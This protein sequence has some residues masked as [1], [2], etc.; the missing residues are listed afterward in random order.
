MTRRF[1]DALARFSLIAAIILANPA[2][3]LS[4]KAAGENLLNDRSILFDGDFS[5]T[6]HNGRPFHLNQ[7]R[8]K[9]ALLFFGY[10]SCA[11][12]CPVAMAKVASVYK[13][14]GGKQQK[15]ATLFVSLDTDRDTP[16]VLAK[17][18]NYFPIK[19]TG[20]TGKRAEIDAVVKQYGAKYEI[21]KSDS[22]LG[23]HINHSTYLYAIDAHGKVR[24]RFNHTD[25]PELI[26]AGLRK[27]AE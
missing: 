25:S 7:H 12:A 26:A 23:Y 13:K 8:G 1:I 20:L 16:A 10:T 17:Y 15:M 11:E 24:F 18:L 4:A 5:L 2:S 27:L 21:E 22:A 3:L 19:A 9:T 14:L 6:D